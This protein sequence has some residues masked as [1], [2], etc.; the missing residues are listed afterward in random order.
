MIE[1]VRYR[2]LY[3]LKPEVNGCENSAIFASRSAAPVSEGNIS[4]PFGC[5]GYI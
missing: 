3:L 4:E 2:N 1:L 5:V